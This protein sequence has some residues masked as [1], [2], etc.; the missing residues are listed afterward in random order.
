MNVIVTIDWF[1][2]E[3][4]PPKGSERVI[5]KAM[6]ARAAIDNYNS[7]SKRKVQ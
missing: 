4:I 6:T 3:G 2:K 5:K 1:L 7:S